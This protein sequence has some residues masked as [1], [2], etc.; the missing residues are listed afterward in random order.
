MD[1]DEIGIRRELG[2]GEYVPCARCGKMGPSDEMTLVPSD[3]LIEG[4]DYEYLCA[5]CQSAL[6]D[7][8]QDLPLTQP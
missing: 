6:A 2:L 7:G 3:A 8:E 4:S 1:E 5:D